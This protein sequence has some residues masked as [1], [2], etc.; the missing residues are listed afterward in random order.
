MLVLAMAI[1]PILRI[2]FAVLAVLA[3]V[4]M[5]DSLKEALV[6]LDIVLIRFWGWSAQMEKKKKKTITV[7]SSRSD[8]MFTDIDRPL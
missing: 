7:W 4:G 8:M 6:S 2:A 5:E 1:P 3:L